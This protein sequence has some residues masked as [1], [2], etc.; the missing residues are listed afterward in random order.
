MVSELCQMM[1][2]RSIY[3]SCGGSNTFVA[4]NH[5]FGRN[6]LILLRRHPGD[7][8]V[9]KAT[10]LKTN[11]RFC[12]FSHESRQTAKYM[13]IKKETQQLRFLNWKRN[14]TNAHEDV[15]NPLPHHESWMSHGHEAQALLAFPC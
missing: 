11:A 3:D 15:R 7:L 8:T 1:L 14:E 12:P 13:L 5:V 6:Y 10:I 9:L 2:L 4:Y